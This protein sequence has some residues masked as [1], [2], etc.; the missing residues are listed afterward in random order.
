MTVDDIAKL[1]KVQLV[2]RDVSKDETE[3]INGDFA[4]V[5]EF[6]AKAHFDDVKLPEDIPLLERE[7]AKMI[8]EVLY[9]KDEESEVER[10]KKEVQSALIQRND[11]EAMYVRYKQKYEKLMKNK[12]VSKQIT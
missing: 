1:V 7:F 9:E 12:K 6:T 8:Y 5:L 10:L 2:S 4:G 3:T 11:F